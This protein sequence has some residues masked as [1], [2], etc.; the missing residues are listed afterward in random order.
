[1]L[2]PEF[3]SMDFLLC[4]KRYSPGV[5]V[6]VVTPLIASFFWP[7][8]LDKDLTSRTSPLRRQPYFMAK[9]NMTTSGKLLAQN[10]QKSFFPGRKSSPMLRMAA[11]KVSGKITEAKIL[12]RAPRS[13]SCIPLNAALRLARSFVLSST[14]TSRV[15]VHVL[16]KCI[17][18]SKASSVF[19][20]YGDLVILEL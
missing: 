7:Q 11:T 13:L 18:A 8:R 1:M 2:L 3:L 14:L 5:F 12:S 6:V 15:V 16:A 20:R 9:A 17:G 10:T 4:H 19:G